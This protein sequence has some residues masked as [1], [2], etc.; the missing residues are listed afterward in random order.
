MH[1]ISIPSAAANVALKYD[2]KFL[3]KAVDCKFLLGDFFDKINCF[4]VKHTYLHPFFSLK[5]W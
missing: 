4:L 1:K 3:F 5:W 2:E